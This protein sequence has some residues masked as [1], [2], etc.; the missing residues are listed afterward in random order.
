M[1]RNAKLQKI[2]ADIAAL[3]QQRQPLQESY[4]AAMK[5]YQRDQVLEA[6][7]TEDIEETIRKY[8]AG[9]GNPR[10]LNLKALLEGKT[11]AQA[12]AQKSVRADQATL[13]AL[14][15]KMAPIQGQID[16]LKVERAT[17]FNQPILIGV[18]NQPVGGLIMPVGG[19]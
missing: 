3:Q 12:I 4:D 10:N 18:K 19:P 1:E 8:K 14:E 9:E 15:D 16:Q 7:T 17:V 6:Q 2:D 5:A 11:A 13:K